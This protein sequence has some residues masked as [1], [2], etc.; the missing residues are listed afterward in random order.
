MDGR[1]RDG[2]CVLQMEKFSHNSALGDLAGARVAEH[3]PSPDGSW[4]P[5]LP[6]GKVPLELG[7]VLSPR[8]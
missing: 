4:V 7:P 8:P 5:G 2:C 1:V 6:R 3:N